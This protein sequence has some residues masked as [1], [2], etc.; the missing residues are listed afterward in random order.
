MIF[1]DGSQKRRYK[2]TTPSLLLALLAALSST[3]TSGFHLPLA[4]Q[5]LTLSRASAWEDDWD[6]SYNLEQDDTQND[7]DISSINLPATTP[8]SHFFSRK[9]LTD[10]SFQADVLFEKLCKGAGLTQPSRIQSLAW[11]VLQSGKHAILAEQTGSGKASHLLSWS[12]WDTEYST[13]ISTE[14]HL[15]TI[16]H[17]RLWHT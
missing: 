4:S 17:H 7:E 13:S 1:L 11:P 8:S 3:S 9:S 14:S 15:I 2:A 6:P 16:F 10:P 12:A 5:R